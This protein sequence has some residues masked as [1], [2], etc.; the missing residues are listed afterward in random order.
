MTVY[1]KD[2]NIFNPYQLI[3]TFTYD[4]DVPQ[5]TMPKQIT[6]NGNR[7]GNCVKSR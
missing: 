6:I 7:P 3:D 4:F 5:G 1:D 2:E